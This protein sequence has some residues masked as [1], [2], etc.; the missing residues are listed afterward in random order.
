MI[1]VEKQTQIA[2]IKD[3]VA[4]AHFYYKKHGIGC[5]L[6]VR[7]GEHAKTLLDVTNPTKLHLVDVWGLDSQLAS[8]FQNERQV[9]HNRMKLFERVKGQ[10]RKE[11]ASGQVEIHRADIADALPTFEDKY[12]DWIYIDAEHY[13]EPV[14]RDIELALPKLKD[15]GILAGHDFM[16]NP[17]KWRTGVPR[18]VLDA[19]QNGL[20]R[21]VALTDEINS[22]W[23]AVKNSPA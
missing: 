5:E 14:M 18:A 3:R 16:V 10:F 22:T 6:G 8:V 7:H 12:F 17:P 20:I 23:V 4:A 1:R 21:V 11:I 15:D 13:Y 2:E 19:V 9:R